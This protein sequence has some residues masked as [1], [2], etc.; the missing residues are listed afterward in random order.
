MQRP[1]PR[2]A[3]RETIMNPCLVGEVECDIFV[4]SAD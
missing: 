2:Y 1:T 4:N 3:N